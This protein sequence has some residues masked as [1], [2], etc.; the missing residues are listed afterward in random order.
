MVMKQ[1]RTKITLLLIIDIAF[2]TFVILKL[3]KYLIIKRH[4]LNKQYF[5][6]ILIYFTRESH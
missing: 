5:D 1:I 3:Y 4:P 6:L 2:G